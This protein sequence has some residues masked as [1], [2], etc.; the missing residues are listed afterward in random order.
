MFLARVEGHITATRKHPS[1]AGWRLLVCQ[2][3]S[4]SGAPEGAPV[5]ALDAQGAGLHQQVVVSGDGARAR[6][7]LDH[8]LSPAQMMIIGLVD[9]AGAAALS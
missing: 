2:P 8:P 1:F 6:H 9:E 5:I 4:A 7:A 3:I